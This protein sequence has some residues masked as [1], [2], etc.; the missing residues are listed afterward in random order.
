[1]IV[2]QLLRISLNVADLARA[3]M[4]YEQALGFTSVGQA[5]D[6]AVADLLGAE[7]ASCLRLRLGSQEIE[8]VATEPAGRSYPA[9]S[10]SADLWF[11]HFAI[12][13][14][15]IGI[16]YRRLRSHPF[17]PISLN[18]PERLPDASGGVTAFKFRDPDGHPLELIQF[19]ART[20]EGID[21]SA[22]SVA[23]AGRSI[24]FYTAL[25]L[26]LAAQQVNTGPEQDRMDALSQVKV[27]VIALRPA[28]ATPHVELLGYR[29]PVGRPAILR[30][31]D[32]AASRLVLLADRAANGGEP[33]LTQ[34]PD[35]HW[36]LLSH[37]TD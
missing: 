37:G 34:D 23:D 25:G 4:F 11:Q 19:P 28:L 24:A 32:I 36:I 22:I 5:Y 27:D 3:Q 9:D 29:N 14:S 21:H 30:P 17:T 18:G 13:T 20:G 8:L 15:D 33:E 2:R 7:S 12:V 16:S 35:G 6:T 31:S 26:S 10:T 1:M